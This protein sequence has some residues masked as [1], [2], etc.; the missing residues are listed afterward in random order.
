MRILV[1]W[2]DRYSA[3]MGVRVLAEGTGLLAQ[4]AWSDV[5]IVE[6]DFA[7]DLNG[8]ALGT[9]GILKDIPKVRGPI[10]E[11]LRSFDLILDTGAGDSF[12]DIYGLKRLLTM[13]YTQ[14][15]AMALGIPLIQ[16]PQTIGPF[17][18]KIGRSIARRTMSKIPLSFSRDSAS[19]SYAE[20]M[21]TPTAARATDV[22]FLLPAPET[23]KTR[24]VVLNVSG[25]LWNENRHVDASSYR[26]WTANLISELRRRGRKVTLLAHVI[27]NNSTDNDCLAVDALSNGEFGQLDVVIPTSL[28]E[29]RGVVASA[30]VVVGARMHACMNALSVG[31]PVI[32]WAYSRKFGPLMADLGWPIA[33]DLA[34][35]VDPVPETLSLMDSSIT[36]RATSDQLDLVRANAREKLDDAVKLLRTSGIGIA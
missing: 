15:L 20:S 24:D 27:A 18:T 29:V 21:G 8:L 28:D 5:E 6:H 3:N 7:P 30:N 23:T 33:V 19:E 26:L 10:K 25:L 35:A 36:S 32:P 13:T 9:R 17:Q 1:L 16:I 4:M 22:V 34:A 2:A 31:T 11:Y 12:T 14:R